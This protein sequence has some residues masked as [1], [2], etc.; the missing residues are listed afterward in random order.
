MLLGTLP[1]AAC[2]DEATHTLSLGAI[3]RPATANAP[4]MSAI[5]AVEH[6]ESGIGSGPQPAA[7]ERLVGLRSSAL[8]GASDKV[9]SAA[10]RSG[11]GDG[12]VPGALLTAALQDLSAHGCPSAAHRSMGVVDF[13][14]SSGTPRMWIVDLDTGAG[15]DRPIHVAHGKGSDP[16]KSG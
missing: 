13:S 15:I 5:K 6:W 3:S 7:A 12:V 14:P 1:A 2:A 11:I 4:R 9:A 16:S 8:C 10:T